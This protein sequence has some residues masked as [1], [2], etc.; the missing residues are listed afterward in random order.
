VDALQTHCRTQC[1]FAAI[2]EILSMEQEDQM[3]SFFL[4]ETLKVIKKKI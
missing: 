3:D 4:S 2:K 1:G